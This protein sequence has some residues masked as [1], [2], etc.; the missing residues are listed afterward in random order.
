MTGEGLPLN[1][2]TLGLAPGPGVEIFV[3]L[4]GYGASSFSW[5]HWVPHLAARGHVLLVDLKGFGAAPR[6]DDGRY[7]PSDQAELVHRLLVQRELTAV[8]L[9]GHSLGGGV[10]LITALRLIDESASRLRRLVIVAGAAYQQ[11]LPPFMLLARF[12]RQS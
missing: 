10:A 9:V 5:R 7:A 6:P 4:H 11:R 2:T 8:T 12:R 3:L 1:V